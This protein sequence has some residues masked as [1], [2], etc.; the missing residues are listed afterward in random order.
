MNKGRPSI[1]WLFRQHG[2]IV[3]SRCYNTQVKNKTI[4]SLRS[5]LSLPRL[6]LGGSLIG[7]IGYGGYQ[8]YQEEQKGRLDSD[9]YLPLTLLDKRN[10]SPD[11]V[12]L[13][14]Q[15][16]KRVG[17]DYP[18]PSCVYIK[19]DA[20]QVM[21]PYTPINANPYRDGFIDLIV[22]RYSNGSVSRTLAGYPLDEPVFVRGPMI[23]EYQYEANTKDEIG[24][25]A[26]GTGISPMYQVIK[27]I[28]ENPQDR[29]TKLWLIYANKSERDILLKQE[30]DALCEQ[31]QDRLKIMYVLEYPSKEWQGEQGRIT[32]EMIVKMLQNGKQ[33]H[34]RLIF[35]CGPDGMMN[36]IC[37]QRARDYSQG[38]LTGIL[39]QLGLTSK[40]VWKFQ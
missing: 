37:G 29:Q 21:R 40:E 36:S 17:E 28:L 23:E 22:K 39:A 5:R 15:T 33:G 8:W 25:I 6:F 30:L 12:R 7:F 20:I 2:N 9:W 31:Y 19:D 1:Q 32:S 13:R 16:K 11:T 35:V 3:W 4:H 18:V 38:K 34:R 14:L 26:G 24:M 27:H 10:I